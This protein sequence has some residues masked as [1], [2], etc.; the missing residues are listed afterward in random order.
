MFL[1]IYA[2]YYAS[3]E[4]YHSFSQNMKAQYVPQ[5]TEDIN[6]SIKLSVSFQDWS[7]F[8]I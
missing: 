7:L 3:E 4:E 8:R 6:R 2:L 1:L 5:I